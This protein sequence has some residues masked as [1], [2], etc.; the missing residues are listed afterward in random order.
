MDI[1]T[2]TPELMEESETL[3]LAAGNITNF[4]A[5]YDRV[6]K[7]AKNLLDVG[8][9]LYDWRQAFRQN[10]GGQIYWAVL[11]TAH[12]PADDGY[13]ERLFPFA[14]EFESLDVAMPVTLSS[15]VILQILGVLLHL[16]R[17]LDPAQHNPEQLSLDFVSS[18]NSS[19]TVACVRILPTDDSLIKVLSNGNTLPTAAS[20]R[21]AADKLA[22]FVCQAVQYCH[23]TELGTLG[24]Q[25]TCHSQWSLRRY[26][27]QTGLTRELEWCQNIKQ[28]TGPDFRGGLD[29]FLMRD[30][31][32]LYPAVNMQ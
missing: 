30:D 8:R 17:L 10:L 7:L 26:F 31:D 14:L 20:I 23:K 16:T 29:L 28:M 2:E 24:P 5:Y 27:R 12:N 25:S 15:G 13:S 9:K 6:S 18:N 32:I 3:L 4:A 11:A 22:R 19:R 21:F 1:V